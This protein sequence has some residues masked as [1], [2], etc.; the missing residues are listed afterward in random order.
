M[1]NPQTCKYGQTV[2]GAGLL[3]LLFGSCVSLAIADDIVPV[4]DGEHGTIGDSPPT[5][6]FTFNGNVGVDIDV[7]PFS[8]SPASSTFVLSGVP[9]SSSILKALMYVQR[10]NSPTTNA[11]AVFSGNAL[12]PI[13]PFAV[14]P[15][16]D[17]Q[18]QSY[19]FDVTNFVTGNGSFPF[20]FTTG[21]GQNFYAALVVI[22]SNTSEPVRTI[23]INDGS[24]AIGTGSSTTTFSALSAGSGTLTIV[25]QADNPG[26]SGESILFNGSTILGPGDI[27]NANLGPFASLF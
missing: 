14:D 17:F 7:V 26:G 3:V 8:G 18:L 9:S 15:A 20:S 21:G 19:R 11:T 22:F 2:R 24:E 13:A 27:F 10:W 12:G 1:K 23:L 16:G 4:S 6:S 25:T 5:T